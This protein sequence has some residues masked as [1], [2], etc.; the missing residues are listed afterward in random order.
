M[1]TP[2]K[3]SMPTNTATEALI[4]RNRERKNERKNVP[5]HVRRKK[6]Y[7]EVAEAREKA[8]AIK[9]DS[10]RGSSESNEVEDG[11]LEG[12]PE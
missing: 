7:Q 1:K 12:S 9:V 8:D 6:F 4:I 2:L 11:V 10:G 3:P 5:V